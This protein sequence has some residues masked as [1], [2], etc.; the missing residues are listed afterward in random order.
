MRVSVVLERVDGMKVLVVIADVDIAMQAL[1]AA[2]ARW[3][4]VAMHGMPPRIS[5]ERVA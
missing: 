1:S 2:L 5:V 3:D 4:D